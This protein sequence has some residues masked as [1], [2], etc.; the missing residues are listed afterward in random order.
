MKRYF[1]KIILTLIISSVFLFTSCIDYVQTITFGEKGY[2]C[3][4]KLTISRAMLEM[5]EEDP[6]SVFEDFEEMTQGLPRGAT[7]SKVDNDVDV[8]YEFRFTIDGFTNPEDAKLFYPYLSDDEAEIYLPFILGQNAEA[9]SSI[10]QEE[11]IETQTIMAGYMATTKCRVMVS[12]TIIPE[13][14]GAYFYGNTFEDGFLDVP[15]YDYGD[16]W[17]LEIPLI[18]FSAR[19]NYDLTEIALE[20]PQ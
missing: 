6:T 1:K 7:I 16:N 2:D 12:K 19:K 8:G 18:Y 20:L 9:F 11:D 5:A 13:I 17:C 15:C 4:F 3:Y 14:E 10:E